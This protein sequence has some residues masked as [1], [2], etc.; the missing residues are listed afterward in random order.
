MLSLFEKKLKD[1]V[2]AYRR[3]SDKPKFISQVISDV[4]KNLS[5]KDFNKKKNAAEILIFLYLEGIPIEFAA[6]NWLE[7]MSGK[8]LSHRRIGF[9]IGSI[10]IKDKNDMITLSSGIFKKIMM[11][12]FEHKYISMGL[13][14]FVS[15]WNN[16]LSQFL[17]EDVIPLFNSSSPMVRRKAV[18]TTYKIISCYPDSLVQLTSY[19]SDALHDVTAAVQIAA[20]TVMYELSRANP[21]LF[22]L[23]VPN[24]FALFKSDNN[25]LIIKLI[26]LMHEVIKVEP[27]MVKKLAKTYQN[28]LVSTK[29]KSVEIDLIREVIVNF[30]SQTELYNLAKEKVLAYFETN[31]NNLLYLGL[32]AVKLIMQNNDHDTTEF[33]SKIVMWFSK[34]DITVRRA[35]LAC[36]QS[37]VNKENVKVIVNDIMQS[38]DELEYGI[39]EI[40]EPKLI[41]KTE[42]KNKTQTSTEKIEQDSEKL[43]EEDEGNLDLKGRKRVKRSFNDSDKSYRD[44]QIKTVLKIL[45][46][47]DYENIDNDFHWWIEIMLKLGVYQGF[48]VNRLIAETLRQ[49]LLHLDDSN[50]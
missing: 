12:S 10:T 23:T 26:K 14:W 47:N 19:L 34:T 20:V 27:R 3:A 24:L 38:I 40:E 50:K 9:L 49:L 48:R 43:D 7:L 45:I 35:A 22:I 11:E 33:K 32:S 2:I 25:W 6:F 13:N 15:V 4:K 8:K 41:N 37:V 44:L 17:C 29:A 21:K 36:I 1:V 28:I 46:D 30:K 5:D 31:D 16:E 18:A 42:D 39:E